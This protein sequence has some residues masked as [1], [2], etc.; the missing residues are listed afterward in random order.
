[1][2]LSCSSDISEYTHIFRVDRYTNMAHLM[3][4]QPNIHVILNY[5]IAWTLNLRIEYTY[6]LLC[7]N[8]WI[9]LEK[10]YENKKRINNEMRLVR[11]IDIICVWCVCMH[12]FEHDL[13]ALIN[14]TTKYEAR[15]ENAKRK[16]VRR[17]WKKE[18][19]EKIKMFEI[20]WRC[21]KTV[22]D[23]FMTSAKKPIRKTNSTKIQNQ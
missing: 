5:D 3:N 9:E 10:K 6:W 17:T 15:K 2:Q 12:R 8:E 19:K 11:L 18:Q 13:T 21:S 20:S 23:A 1:M 16:N 7:P 14:A 22:F 4:I